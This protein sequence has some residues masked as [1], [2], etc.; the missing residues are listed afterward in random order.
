M[1]Y[2]TIDQCRSCGSADLVTV[3]PLGSVPLA[4]ALLDQADAPEDRYPLTLAF[5]LECSLVQILETVPA[6]VLFG[7]DYPYFSSFSDELLRHSREHVES[8]IESRDLDPDAL[9]VEI[10]SNDGYLLRHFVEK[11]V[12]VLGIDPTPGPAAAAREVGVPTEERFFGLEYADELVADGV[13]ADVIIGNNVLA[14]VTDQNDFVAGIRRLLK[15]DG[16]AVLEFPY[17][18]DLVDHCEFDTIY[19]E[20]ACYFSV[21]SVRAL[22]ARHGLH[23]IDVL[24]L[25]I[26]GGSL[27][28]TASPT[29]VDSPTT[30]EFLRS[31]QQS[32]VD[33]LSYYTEFGTR[34]EKLRADLRHL[35][36]DL[37]ERGAE[38]AGYGAAAKGT[39]LL[40]YCGIGREDLTYIADRNVHKQ[41]KFMPGARIEIVAPSRIESDPPDYLLILPWN[42]G[43]EIRDQQTA[44]REAG[45]RFI[46]P[47]PTPVIL[48]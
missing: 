25:P 39:S 3:L 13:H 27:R 37:A 35:L 41:G 48:P 29:A 4:D 28:I 21:T 15:D 31:E 47:V 20:H 30:A 33:S 46:I 19:H 2:E 26:H 38:V 16:I 44:F 12:P 9:V 7:A 32:D 17:V 43:E 10:A 5:C 11:G 24:H 34:V 42:F 40:A 8:L 6:D 18:K 22:F 23:L 36:D 45:G 1:N 14:H